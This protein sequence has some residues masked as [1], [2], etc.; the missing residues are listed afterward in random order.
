VFATVRKNFRQTINNALK[1]HLLPKAAEQAATILN[2]YDVARSYLEKTLEQEAEEKIARNSRLQAEIQQKIDLYQQS[3]EGINDCLKAMQIADQ[4]PLIT[5]T[6]TDTDTLSSVV[7]VKEVT[8]AEFVEI[9]EEIDS[10]W[11]GY[12]MEE[13]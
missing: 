2:Q 5:N 4:L 9:K 11:E 6:D 12:S 10:D 13:I 8:D 1:T 3:I 7:E